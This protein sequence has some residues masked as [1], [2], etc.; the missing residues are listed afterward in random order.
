MRAYRCCP[1]GR[2]NQLDCQ[3]GNAPPVLFLVLPKKR[4]R[5]ARCK[6]KRRSGRNFA[7]A[8]KVAV[9]GSAYR[10]LLRF[11]LAFGHAWA[12]CEVDTA[13]LWQIVR[14]SSGCKNAFDQRLFYCL[15]LQRSQ[16]FFRHQCSTGSSFRAFRFATRCPGGR[17]NV[18][19]AHAATLIDH[20]PAAAKRGA[21][22]IPDFPGPK[23]SPRAGRFRP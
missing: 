21:A 13:V 14:R 6:R 2:G 9:R 1:V 20:R 8:C 10:C 22:G 15:A 23:V 12:F 17:R 7:H 3:L 18:A 19:L 16:Y 11:G 5:R 4:T